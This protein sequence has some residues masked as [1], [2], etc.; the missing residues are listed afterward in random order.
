MLHCAKS[1]EVSTLLLL[2]VVLL[3][4]RFT[5]ATDTM[6]KTVFLVGPEPQPIT[7]D[8]GGSPIGSSS[9]KR[10]FVSV[11]GAINKS[12]PHVPFPEHSVGGR[13]VNARRTSQAP[14]AGSTLRGRNRIILSQV[15]R[16]AEVTE[17]RITNT[18]LG[19]NFADN[20]VKTGTARPPTNPQGAAGISRLVA[21]GNSMMEVRQKDGTLMYRDSF[22][23]FF[24]AITASS[25]SAKFYNPKVIF[26]EHEGRYVV[27]VLQRVDTTQI[28]RIWLAVSKDETPDAIGDWNQ[29]YIDIAFFAAGSWADNLGLEVDEEDVYLTVNAFRFADSFYEGVRIAWFGKG[30]TDGL[31]AGKPLFFFFDNPFATSGIAATT[32]PAQVHGSSGVDGSVG[33]FFASVVLKGSG[34]VDLQIYTIFNP[35]TTTYSFALQTISLG[36]I[37]Q[38]TQVPDA[39]QLGSPKQI[40]TSTLMALDAVWRD[41]KLWVVF[42]ANPANGVNQNQATA[43]WVRLTTIGGAVTLDAQGDLGGEDIAT[44]A[45][46]YFPSVAVNSKATV[47]YGYAAS[48]QTT[49]VGA[50][51]SIGISEKSLIVKNGLDPY[52]RTLS[53][54]NGWGGYTGISVDPTDDSFWVFNQYADTVGSSD[55]GGFGRWGTAWG[56][57]ACFVSCS[58]F[59]VFKRSFERRNSFVFVLFPISDRT[60][61]QS[62]CSARLN[63]DGSTL[64]TSPRC[65]NND[66]PGTCASLYSSFAAKSSS[67]SFLQAL[68]IVWIGFVLSFYIMWPFWTLV[69]S[70]P[71]LKSPL[72]YGVSVVCVDDMRFLGFRG[73]D[74]PY[75]LKVNT[76]IWEFINKKICQNPSLSVVLVLFV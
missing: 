11:K 66:G 41:N 67:R 39:P 47:A 46:T 36:V 34:Q 32:V 72:S 26:D 52:V 38:I 62:S 54:A 50:Y 56:R 14:P 13:K 1:F 57:L 53:D 68:W 20:V 28:S 44:G 7:L 51:A 35:H 43:H 31:Y 55:V 5:H 63:S 4:Q 37:N 30:V 74:D 17:C 18:I 12:V 25:E 75:A 59:C 22:Q 9:T 49:Y 45:F 15:S 70:L 40:G 48:S 60:S 65:S 61:T 42:T 23:D 10:N 29:N 2:G 76:E 73:L 33:T 69:W 21:V 6:N 71:L 27:G 8:T 3:S 24:S 58:I 19:F 64:P 16:S